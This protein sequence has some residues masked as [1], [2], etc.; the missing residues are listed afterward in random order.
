MSNDYELSEEYKIFSKACCWDNNTRDFIHL[1]L[2]PINKP[3][4]LDDYFWVEIS[5]CSLQI[6]DLGPD[7]FCDTEIKLVSGRNIY[8]DALCLF[9]YYQGSRFSHK[10]LNIAISEL[11][12]HHVI[13]KPNRV[14]KSFVAAFFYRINKPHSFKFDEKHDD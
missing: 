6:N 14:I 13:D 5:F 8:Q 7:D 2:D 9:E 12:K 11:T 1:Y 10:C 3:K 4:D